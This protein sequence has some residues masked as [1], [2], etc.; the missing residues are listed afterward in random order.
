M[1]G[2]GVRKGPPASLRPL[3]GGPP[4]GS[5]PTGW[6]PTPLRNFKSARQ[7]ADTSG[8]PP[9]RSPP[10]PRPV[11][12][13]AGTLPSPRSP[14]ASRTALPGNHPDATSPRWPC[15]AHPTAPPSPSPSPTSLRLQTPSKC[16]ALPNAQWECGTH[17]SSQGRAD[18]QRLVTTRL[19]DRVH[20]PLGHFSRLQRI[21]PRAW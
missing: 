18:A 7:L 11:R 10:P 15:Q 3:Q 19:L 21:H 1:L 9:R 12:Q 14:A 6:L 8:V 4:T 2:T 16:P 17:K 13:L 20:D 5:P